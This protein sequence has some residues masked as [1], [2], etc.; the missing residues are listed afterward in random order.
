[1]KCAHCLRGDKQNINLDEDN[2]EK[3]FDNNEVSIKKIKNLTITGGEP[4][5]NVKVILQIIKNIIKKNIIVEKFTI[6]T[7]GSI[8]KQSLVD[9]LNEFY[10]YY[11][12]YN[13]SNPQFYLICSQDQFHRP[14][15]KETI[16]HYQQLP[17]FI[18]DKLTLSKDQIISMGY[19]YENN[20]GNV[21]LRNNILFLFNIYK[22]NNYPVIES[23]NED[24]AIIDEL[25]LSAKGLYGFH[26]YDVPFKQI[27]EM[28]V[29]NSRQLF[30][31]IFKKNRSYSNYLLKKRK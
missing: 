14:P 17:Y 2:I 25:Y 23:E 28:C 31:S 13:N 30:N 15:K 29:Y 4:T 24:M 27:D 19:A 12:K 20:L 26:I 8:Y 6:V 18:T 3:L 16:K 7:N 5:L 10:K 11:L 1:M 21:Q 22:D 9:G